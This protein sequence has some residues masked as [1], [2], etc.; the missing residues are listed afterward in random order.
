MTAW[1]ARDFLGASF[2]DPLDLDVDRQHAINFS[3]S[4]ALLTSFLTSSSPAARRGEAGRSAGALGAIGGPALGRPTEQPLQ[5]QTRRAGAWRGEPV[6]FQRVSA[7]LSSAVGSLPNESAARSS[8][9]SVKSFHDSMEFE[10][11]AHHQA[12]NHADDW[13]AWLA[14]VARPERRQ[15]H[16]AGPSLLL[17][18]LSSTGHLG[19]GGESACDG[20]VLPSIG[21]RSDTVTVGR[22][23]GRCG[24]V[25]PGV[26]TATAPY[27]AA[28]ASC[29]VASTCEAGISSGSAGASAS[30]S[31]AALPERTR[32]ALEAAARAVEALSAA[33]EAVATNDGG[34]GD[35]GGRRER[36]RGT[37]GCAATILSQAVPPGAAGSLG[38][39]AESSRPKSPGRQLA[40][41]LEAD[42]HSRG[43]GLQAEADQLRR[44]NARLRQRLVAVERLASA[45]TGGAYARRAN[46][47]RRVAAGS[48]RE[49]GGAT[50][51]VPEPKPS[52][53]FGRGASVPILRAAC[54]PSSARYHEFPSRRRTAPE[55]PHVVFVE[56]STVA[57]RRRASSRDAGTPREC[58]SQPAAASRSPSTRRGAGPLGLYGSTCDGGL[59]AGAG[60]SPHACAVSPCQCLP[61]CCCR[62]CCCRVA[63]DRRP[64]PASEVWELVEP[65]ATGLR[66]PALAPGSARYSPWSPSPKG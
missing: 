41:S 15:P 14:A 52:V 65:D 60:A 61:S 8:R 22:P 50:F 25:S 43:T 59:A 39:Q 66:R 64:E 20:A 13:S 2:D 32:R 38:R 28:V 27:T 49:R 45:A 17:P 44:E 31:P 36:G 29:A 24:M 19:V 57:P 3:D 34:V 9:D 56:H 1:P 33:A 48:S 47:G 7:A 4:G 26:A 54:S 11:V 53:A 42:A 23:H 30:A 18:T 40:T 55:T 21:H 5:Q 62:C 16:P 35:S 10:G 46:S 12:P 51:A 63:A 37:D 58:R 6:Q